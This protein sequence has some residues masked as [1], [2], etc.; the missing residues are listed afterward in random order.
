MQSFGQILNTILVRFI[1]NPDL[2]TGVTG[3][4]AFTTPDLPTGNTEVVRVLPSDG[5]VYYGLL[6]AMAPN[7]YSGSTVLGEVD[8]PGRNG[9]QEYVLGVLVLDPLNPAANPPDSFTQVGYVDAG[10][11]VFLDKSP[12]QTPVPPTK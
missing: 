5:R 7:S 10:N 3:V 9:N 1:V 11:V 6:V 4:Q 12:H 8:E 2:P